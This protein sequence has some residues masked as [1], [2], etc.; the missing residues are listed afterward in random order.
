M[1]SAAL[2]A[3]VSLSAPAAAPVAAGYAGDSVVAAKGHPIPARGKVARSSAPVACHPEPSKG[4][5][6]RH[7]VVQAEQAE[8]AALAHADAAGVVVAVAEGVR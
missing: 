2:L 7:N 6:C 3:L 4:R 1:I 5:V 8:R